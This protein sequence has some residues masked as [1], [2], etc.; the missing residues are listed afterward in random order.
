MNTKKIVRELK[1]KEHYFYL[2]QIDKLEGQYVYCNGRKMINLAS[3]SYLGLLGHPD[4]DAYAKK[5]IDDYGTGTHGVRILAGT[6]PYHTELEKTIADF[7]HR[8]DSIV[9]SSGYTANLA[10]ISTLFGRHDAVICDKYDHASIVDGCLLSGAEFVRFN[11][12]DLKNLELRL[13]QTQ[14]YNSRCV[15]IDGVYSMDGDIAPIPEIIKLCKQYDT[16]LFVDEAHSVG[17]LGK[18]GTGVEEYFNCY[19]EIDILMGTLS[20]VIPSMGGYIAGDSE[21]ISHLKHRSR[22]FVFSAAL[23]PANTAAATASFRVIQNE[24]WRIKKLNENIEY[25]IGTLRNLGFNLLDTQTAII[26]L[27]IPEEE[28]TWQ[29]CRFMQNNDIFVLPVVTPA[30]PPNTSRLR[31]NVSAIMT[32]DDLDNVVNKIKEADK[33]FKIL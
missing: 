27:I 26:P 1:E 3:Y 16:Y 5:A 14:K 20:K 24:K 7:K 9:F 22:A 10:T 4:I 33:I 18:N 15:I 29:V 12:N 11:H 23:T 19:G 25:F 17:V 6:I 30:V 21:L 8:D 32:R 2:Q 28:K 13:Q 31:M